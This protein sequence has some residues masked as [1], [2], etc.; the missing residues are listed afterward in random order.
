MSAKCHP[1][2]KENPGAGT[3]P[4]LF[5]WSELGC[6]GHLR[7]TVSTSDGSRAWS[8]C[9]QDVADGVQKQTGWRAA[10]PSVMKLTGARRLLADFT[11]LRSRVRLHLFFFPLS[12]RK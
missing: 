4:A 1:S 10:G 12:I 6:W 9:I 3:G 7:G 2:P 5:R 8:P 11:G